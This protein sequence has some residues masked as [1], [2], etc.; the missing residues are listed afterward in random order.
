ME[1]EIEEFEKRPDLVRK[2]AQALFWKRIWRALWVVIGIA[3]LTFLVYSS[4]VANDSRQ[5]IEEC[6]NPGG[7]CYE[8]NQKATGQAV[9]SI[10]EGVLAGAETNHDLTR[11]IILLTAWCQDHDGTQ[12][13]KELEECVNTELK[14]EDEV[15]P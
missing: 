7:Q 11:K 4:I 3:A 2:R 1:H 5:R 13:L 9:A 12:T 8:D 15:K 6:T 10:V 14:K